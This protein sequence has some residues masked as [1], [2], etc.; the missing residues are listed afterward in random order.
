MRRRVVL[1]VFAGLL[2][3]LR[4]WG[5]KAEFNFYPEFRSEVMPKH[6]LANPRTTL[7]EIV[8][9]YSTDLKAAGQAFRD[10]LLG[11]V[12]LACQVSDGEIG[13]SSILCGGHDEWSMS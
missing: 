1:Y 13:D 8:S 12:L 4:T 10:P 9:D 6:Y 11:Q 5:Q 7:S 2:V 3:C